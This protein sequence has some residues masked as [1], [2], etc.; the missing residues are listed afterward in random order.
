MSMHRLLWRGE[1]QATATRPRAQHDPAAPRRVAPAS[2]LLLPRCTAIESSSSKNS[3]QGALPRALSK[4]SL[5][6]WGGGGWG[7]VGWGGAGGLTE[8]G[9]ARGKRGAS[10]CARAGGTRVCERACVCNHTTQHSAI[11]C[12]HRQQ[13]R[14]VIALQIVVGAGRLLDQDAR[15]ATPRVLP[16][17]PPAHPPAHK[18][19]L[20][21]AGTAA[22]GAATV[23][24]A[25]TP[26]HP[27]DPNPRPA[28]G[29]PPPPAAPRPRA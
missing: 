13:L 29:P 14:H 17:R 5:G 15:P 9:A 3:T 8:D 1:R 28:R 18:A 26:S 10:A 4:I 12:V 11:T 23:A 20:P 27:S 21:P 2:P 24:P 6:G 19:A 16:P 25:S 7:G 22:A